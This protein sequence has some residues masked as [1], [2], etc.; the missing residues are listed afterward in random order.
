MC[1]LVCTEAGSENNKHPMKFHTG[2]EGV[3]ALGGLDA[4]DDIPVRAFL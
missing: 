2:N 1:A 3:G 4:A